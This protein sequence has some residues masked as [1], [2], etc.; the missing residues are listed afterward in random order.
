MPSALRFWPIDF[1][2]AQTG[3]KRLAQ[4]ASISRAV[5]APSISNVISSCIEV[6][7]PIFSL[8]PDASA[9]RGLI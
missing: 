1:R 7:T 5:G 3:C 8:K 4:L 9:G 6:F 2:R